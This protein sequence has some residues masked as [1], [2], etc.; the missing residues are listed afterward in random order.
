VSLRRSA[1]LVPALALALATLG[2]PASAGASPLLRFETHGSHG[3]R[4]LVEAHGPRTQISITKAHDHAKAGSQTTYIA[5]RQGGDG[6]IRAGF[7]ELGSISMRFRPD[8]RVTETKPEKTCIGPDHL[9]IRH[10][11]YVGKLRFRGED[12][13]VTVK[14]NRVSGELV[15][16]PFLNCLQESGSARPATFALAARKGPSRF[17]FSAGYRSG[18]YAAF[19]EA[20]RSGRRT[21]FVATVLQTVGKIGIYRLAIDRDKPSSFATNDSLS[22]A[23]IAPGAPFHGSGSLTRDPLGARQWSGSLAVNFPGAPNTP[24][25]GPLFKTG[26]TRSF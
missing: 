20:T 4:V 5:H 25:T 23:A 21:E 22:F 3:Y 7:G 13:Y 24:L 6:S 8:G 16:P 14:A 1:L 2:A 26:L 11:S 17:R 15:T 10:G 18:L 9:T 19:F 12:G